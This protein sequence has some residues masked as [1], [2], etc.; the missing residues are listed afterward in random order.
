M[1]R[2]LIVRVV[3]SLAACV[4]VTSIAARASA[5]DGD[6]AA[7]QALFDEA[8]RLVKAGKLDQACPKFLASFKLD[9]TAGTLLNLAD[10]YEREGRTASAWARYVETATLASRSGPPE[11]EKYARDHAAA[12][13]PKLSRLTITV[14]TPMTGMRVLRDGVLLDGAAVGTAIP[15]DPGAHTVEATAPGKKPWSSSITIAAGGA[16]ATAMVPTL[17]DSVGGGGAVTGTQTGGMGTQRTVALI[18]GGAGIL[19]V[20]LGS[21]FGLNAQSTWA[22]A[23]DNHCQNTVCDATGVTQNQDAKSSAT[24]STIAFVAGGA[25]LAGGAVLW[26]TAPSS[27]A[28]SGTAL[29]VAP[30]FGPH[31]ATLAVRG[32]F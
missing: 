23:R 28:A 26:F 19:G 17:E 8:G 2:L 14:A 12:L 22:D 3:L 5:Q 15:V 10:C 9:A 31:A 1:R 6:T 21:V 20:V 16:Q 18:V 24:A 27:H 4:A 7:A 13:E 30:G 29:Q 11:R 25:L 32:A